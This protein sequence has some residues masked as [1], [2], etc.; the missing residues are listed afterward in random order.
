MCPKC[1]IK[2]SIRKIF[3]NL[4]FFVIS[5]TFFYNVSAN[6]HEHTKKS[7]SGEVKAR[8]LNV[9]ESNEKLHQAFFKYDVENVEKNAK[10]LLDSINKINDPEIAKLLNFSKSKLKEIGTANKREENNQNYHLVSMALIHILN[11]YN[12][13]NAYKAYF[14]PMVKKKWIQNTK[15]LDEVQNPYASNMPNCGEQLK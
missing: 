7:L 1:E 5:F 13:G 9:F 12:L 11:T 2:L 15:E 8:L 6:T 3:F 14:C 4:S 10:Q